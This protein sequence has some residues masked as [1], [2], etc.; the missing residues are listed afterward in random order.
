MPAVSYKPRYTVE[1]YLGWEGDWELWDGSA[2]SMAPSP[3]FGHN[4]AASQLL[5]ELKR[6]FDEGEG[7]TDCA[8]V[9]E[10]DWHVN[11]HTVVR[12]DLSVLCGEKPIDWIKEAPVMVV[13][14]LSPSTREKDLTVKRELYAKEG[15]RFYVIGDPESKELTILELRA[16]EY[17]E[18]DGCAAA[19]HEDCVVSIDREK[20]FS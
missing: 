3:L 14:F 2:V 18:L 12:P 1:D 13:E 10:V 7:C 9:Y 17:E 15:V 6:Q 5:G 20:I 16:G 11:R 8:V 19:L 4:W